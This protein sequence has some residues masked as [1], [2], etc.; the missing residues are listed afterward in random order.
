MARESDFS[1]VRG[2]ALIEWKLKTAT[3]LCIKSGTISAWQ[4]AAST[5]GKMRQVDAFLDF[6]KKEQND[7]KASL[8]DFYHDASIVNGTLKV[9][10]RIPASSV[11]GALRSY[12]IKRLVPKS[13]WGDLKVT[14]KSDDETDSAQAQAKERAR[15]ESALNTPGWHLIQNLFGMATDSG[16]DALEAQ[17]VAGRLSVSA[18]GLKEYEKDEFERNLIA[19]NFTE[20]E[21]GSTHGKMVITTRNPLD[22]ITQAAKSGGL[23]SFM[24]L[25]PGNEF[26][27]KLRIINPSPSDLGLVAFWEEGFEA[28]LLRIGGLT[29]TGRGRVVVESQT[30]SVFGRYIK[31][32]D[33]LVELNQ[34]AE[35]C[36]SGILTEHEVGDW[37]AIK[38]R[39]LKRLY[40]FFDSFGKESPDVNL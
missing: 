12:T 6:Y 19:G 25:A 3:K 17:T 28:G 29:S 22:R 32:F 15:I 20:C 39:Y 37:P 5:K 23:H 18:D 30:V 4:Q 36:L 26:T 10:Y 40:G 31:G 34:R 8:A 21:P 24:E 35:D 11:R 9:R 2:V 1:A 27:V 14:K 13:R 16:D 33:G 38:K 7:E